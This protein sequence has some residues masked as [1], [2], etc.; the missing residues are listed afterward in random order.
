MAF[1]FDATLKQLVRDRPRDWLAAFG[2]EVVGEVRMASA[3]LSAVSAAADVVLELGDEGDL[4]A[5]FQS[6]PDPG[7]P[8]RALQYNAIRHAQSGRPVHTVIVLLHPQA[9]SR[10]LTGTVRY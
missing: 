4:H 3:D 2:I 7:L 1:A 6:G 5:E 10:E 8:R 9:D